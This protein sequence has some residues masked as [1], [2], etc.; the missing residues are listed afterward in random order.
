MTEEK[1]TKIRKTPE[2]KVVET[3]LT[4]IVVKTKKAESHASKGLIAVVRIDGEVKVKSEIASTLD[5][6][7]LRRKYS[8]VL[9]NSENKGLMGMLWKVRHAVA[10]GPIENE[11]LVKLLNARAKVIKSTSPVENSKTAKVNY[12]E[13]AKEIITGKKLE[14]FK[15]KPFFRLH[16]PR[17]GIKS[18]LQY[19]KG[20]LG[21]NKNDI[22][23]LIERML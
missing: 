9:I 1:I 18:K 23:K 22:N 21:N 7:R 3:K 5:R 14:D 15:L 19:P 20:V 10:Y 13:A 16:P 2:K 12:E 17:K 8:C 6:L 4:K 11:T